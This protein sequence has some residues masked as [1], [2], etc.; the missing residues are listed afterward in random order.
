VA[1]DPAFLF[2]T[3]DFLTGTMLMT[4]EQVG[5]YIRVM[6][7]EHQHGR[8]T[9]EDML[10][11]CSTYDKD[12]F[13]KFEKDENGNYFNE[14]LEEEKNK[15]K[16]YSDSRKANRTNICKTY[17]KDMSNI[18]K[19]YVEHMEDEDVNEN[20]TKNKNKNDMTLFPE[21]WNLYPKKVAKKDAE[22]A[23]KKIS[24]AE[25]PEIIQS[26]EKWKASQGWTKDGGQFIPNAATW[27]NG[28]R[29]KDEVPGATKTIELTPTGKGSW[30]L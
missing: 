28:E 1:K 24:L 26:L 25:Y 3:S 30:K 11:I 21:F 20:I 12:I 4:N 8:L 15:R 7:Y 27:L 19:T 2:Y 23:W 22:R 6:C 29:W 18:C 13:C 17:D 9:E 5:K 14:R 16:A 10:K